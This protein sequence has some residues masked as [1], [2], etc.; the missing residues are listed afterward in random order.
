M[1]FLPTTITRLTATSCPRGG[2]W[3]CWKNCL[4]NALAAC[5]HQ[6]MCELAGG[7]GGG[8]GHGRLSRLWAVGLEE[9]EEEGGGHGLSLRLW[10]DGQKVER[11]GVTGLSRPNCETLRPRQIQKRFLI[12]SSAGPCSI[13]GSDFPNILN[14]VSWSATSRFF[15]FTQFS[16]CKFQAFQT[17]SAPNFPVY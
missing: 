1:T 3:Q 2:R 17:F 16:F 11:P 7:G 15:L 13:F 6:K 12:F 10:R 9:Q 14:A 4:C 5:L 8:S